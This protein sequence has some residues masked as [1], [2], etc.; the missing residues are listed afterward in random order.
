MK[1]SEQAIQSLLRPC[2]GR[3][4][5]IFSMVEAAAGE[6]SNRP[7][8]RR[9]ICAVR[10]FCRR[11]NL[12]AGGIHFRRAFEIPEGGAALWAAEPKKERHLLSADVFL[13]GF[14]RPKGRLPLRYPNARGRQ[15]RPLR[16]G[17]GLRPKRLYAAKTT[18]LDTQ[19]ASTV[20]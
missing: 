11:Q 7:S 14:R 9:R 5:S 16:Q 6:L 12:G 19:G 4:K 2:K 15:S 1:K 13:F 10:A 18:Q 20:Q 17:F 8:G 3:L